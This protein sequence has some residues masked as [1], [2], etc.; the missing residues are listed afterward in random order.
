MARTR[1]LLECARDAMLHKV[2][3]RLDRGQPSVAG[4][5]R[6]ATGALKVLQELEHERCVKV[7][8]LQG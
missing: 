3:E 5:W 6:V 8:E 4:A 2:H 7:F 1:L